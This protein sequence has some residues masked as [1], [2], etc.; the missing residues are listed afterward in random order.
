MTDEGEDEDE[1][2]TK[3]RKVS[4][5]TPKKTPKKVSKENKKK[6]PRKPRRKRRPSPLKGTSKLL[7]R[8]A[9]MSR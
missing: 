5:A 4:K 7:R 9:R 2:V 6:S 8:L 1:V 3:K